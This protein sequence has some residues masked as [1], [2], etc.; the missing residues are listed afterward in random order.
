MFLTN[1]K[2]YYDFILFFTL[3]ISLMGQIILVNI[4]HMHDI[5]KMPT[6]RQRKLTYNLLYM[7]IHA[8]NEL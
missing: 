8:H 1:L 6:T 7:F 3:F 4:P 2:L 5:K